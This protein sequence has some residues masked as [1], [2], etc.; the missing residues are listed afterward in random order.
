MA[1][2]GTWVLCIHYAQTTFRVMNRPT[3]GQHCKT[4][5]QGEGIEHKKS[6]SLETLPTASGGPAA[7]RQRSGHGPGTVRARPGPGPSSTC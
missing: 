7:V 1:L 5:N 2:N 4:A 3:R 6:Y